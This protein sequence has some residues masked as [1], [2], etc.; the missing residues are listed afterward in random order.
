MR[1]FILILL[2]A[3]ALAQ[4]PVVGIIDVY[5][6]R[7][8]S[9][10]EIRDFLGLKTGAPMP[11]SKG[12]LE[13]RL[14]VMPGVVAAHIEA[15]CCAES[16]AILYVGIEERGAPHFDY[17]APP[18]E[19]LELPAEIVQGYKRF[20]EAVRE[21][22]RAGQPTEDLSKGHSL[23]SDPPAREVQTTFIA[24][25]DMHLNGIQKVLRTAVDPEQRAIAAYVIGY[26]TKKPVIIADLQHAL[27]DSDDTVR[28][29]AMRSLAALAVLARKDTTL[30]ISATW[31]V[32]ML[33]SVVWSDRNNA[34]VALVNLTD[35]R[36]AG[37]LA[38]IKERALF[39][40]TEMAAWQYLPHAL[41][42]YIVLG[43]VKGYPEQKLQELWSAGNRDTV[44]KKSASAPR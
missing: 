18:T 14:E 4:V 32:E 28:S 42:A 29:N 27:R 5:G 33:N 22:A 13:E 3:L 35:S 26:T 7:K 30:R 16:K 2:P 20:L 41:P 8:S 43:R 23:L 15:V 10:A 17:H 25:A 44:I 19:V 12:D 1:K 31:L 38:Q 34:A 24:L 11:A 39:S 40:L 36:D 37:V 6:V 9:A 21:A